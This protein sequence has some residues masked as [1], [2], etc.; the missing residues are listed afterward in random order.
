MMVSFNPHD[1]IFLLKA[2]GKDYGNKLKQLDTLCSRRM[3]TEKW[4]PSMHVIDVCVVRR[5]SGDTG[6]VKKSRVS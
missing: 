2:N 3:Q 1:H 5:L 4:L 6:L